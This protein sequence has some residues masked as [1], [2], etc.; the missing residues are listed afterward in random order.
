MEIESQGPGLGQPKVSSLVPEDIR[1]L[2]PRDD[3]ISALTPEE[4]SAIA[5]FARSLA[6][7]SWLPGAFAEFDA[8]QASKNAPK[9]VTELLY[10]EY[11]VTPFLPGLWATEDFAVNF[12]EGGSHTLGPRVPEGVRRFVTDMLRIA[13][14][15]MRTNSTAIQHVQK[16]IGG[17]FRSED[18]YLS[19]SHETSV[20]KELI[21][22][23]LNAEPTFMYFAGG[24][25]GKDTQDILIRWPGSDI[26]VECKALV[27]SVAGIDRMSFVRMAYDI[28]EWLGSSGFTGIATL[29]IP[30]EGRRD[31]LQDLV[32]EVLRR[33]PFSHESQPFQF[34]DSTFTFQLKPLPENL[35]TDEL[36]KIADD[37]EETEKL[38]LDTR[39]DSKPNGVRYILCVKEEKTD[40]IGAKIGRDIKKALDQIG[41]TRKGIVACHLFDRVI[42]PKEKNGVGLTVAK[43]LD[44][45][46]NENLMGLMVSSEA[47]FQWRGH[48]IQP[49][50]I[51]AFRTD[52]T[53]SGFPP[54]SLRPKS[55]ENSA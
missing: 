5:E 50:A 27:T 29:H 23:G 17:K 26:P 51:Y 20:F 18:G 36:K 22:R 37:I 39:T 15:L 3:N 38:L 42:Y 30:H 45:Y 54:T 43:L 52:R 44:D 40:P 31:R 32:A 13:G 47:D 10:R 14:T 4:A 34:G 19:L 9:L 28:G 7:P 48:E 49:V 12:V 53:P 41:L 25:V 21:V 8:W 24:T 16:N 1:Y 46:G 35:T 55:Q 33:D 6:D 2:I 11:K